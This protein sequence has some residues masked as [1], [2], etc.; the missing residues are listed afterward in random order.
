MIAL[1]GS[2]SSLGS[3]GSA[4][5]TAA[6]VAQETVGSTAAAEADAIERSEVAPVNC[7]PLITLE[8]VYEAFDMVGQNAAI[9]QFT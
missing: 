2:L 1:V 4:T 9:F 3:D 7:G 5:T 6:L 8:E